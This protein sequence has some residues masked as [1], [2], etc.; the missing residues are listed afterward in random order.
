[1]QDVFFSP[2]VLSHHVHGEPAIWF[3]DGTYYMMYDYIGWNPKAHANVKKQGL[4]LATSKDGVYWRDHGIDFPNDEDV[5]W[6]GCAAV[7]RY[8]PDGPWVMQ[9]SFTDVPKYPGFR[10]RFAVS[11]DSRTWEKLGPESTF[12][13]DPRWYTNRR[14]DTI[15]PCPAP[16]GGYWY[17]AW[18]AVPKDVWGFGFGKTRDGIQWEVLP[19]V[20]VV[21]V[22]RIK[23]DTIPG[24]MGGFFKMGDRYFIEYCDNTHASPLGVRVHIVSSKKPEGPYRPTPRNHTWGTYSYFYPRVYDLPGGTFFAE[25]FHVG[26]DNGRSYHM[27]PLKRIESDGESIWL[28][29]WEGNDRLKSQ[30]IRLS[31]VEPFDDGKASWLYGVP[32]T[33]PYGNAVVVEGK[34]RLDGARGERNLALDATATASATEEAEWNQADS[35]SP[36]KAIDGNPATGWVGHAPVGGAVSFQLDLGESQSIGSIALHA[37]VPPDFVET[38]VDGKEWTVVPDPPQVFD[39][40]NYSIGAYWENLGRDARFVRFT[41][42]NAEDESW[43]GLP[44]GNPTWRG[45][46]GISDVGVY[47]RPSKSISDRPSLVLR[48]EGERDFAIVVDRDGTV[49]FG[50]VDKDGTHFRREH[51]RD[52]EVDLGQQADFRLILREDMGEFYLNDY[53]IGLLNLAGTNPLIGRI[54]FTGIDGACRASDL[55]AW[56]SD[57]DAS[58]LASSASGQL[59]F[60]DTFNATAGA[61]VGFNN[62]ISTRQAASSL[63]NAPYSYDATGSLALNGSNVNIVAAGSF[64]PDTSDT[65]AVD[66]GAELVGEIYT[67]SF[68]LSNTSGSSGDWIGFGFGNEAVGANIADAG[69]LIRRNG[70]NS[71]YFADGSGIQFS[72]TVSGVNTWE[73]TVDET[74]ASPTVQFFQNGSALNATPITITNLTGTDRTFQFNSSNSN[75]TGTFDNLRIEVIP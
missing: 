33:L 43:P 14:F 23:K 10:M 21:E 38:S 65:L 36:D 13:P 19:P 1:M 11:E 32:E 8:Q 6:T 30:P 55:K 41:K 20:E 25:M 56:H 9:Y 49:R 75:T 47:A 35:F 16:D 48:R 72:S 15:N 37:S 57:P 5:Y 66:L 67:I 69:L 68:E 29:Y 42:K 39:A 44:G 50:G 74:G 46:F 2:T 22:P 4:G 60:E 64:T 63:A 70:S 59:V 73:I 52:I 28:K 7:T 3:D 40:R 12:L 17:G 61:A 51:V 58:F 45:Y 34:L 71:F 53:Q 27:P 54:G 31:A 62:D 24:E 18:I 26:R